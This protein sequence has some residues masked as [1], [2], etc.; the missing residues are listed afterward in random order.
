MDKTETL[1][2]RPCTRTWP[3]LTQA[4]ALFP[5]ASP[6][7]LL[8]TAAGS[9]LTAKRCPPSHCSAQLTRTRGE[10]RGVGGPAQS[11]CQQPQPATHGSFAL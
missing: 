7:C 10:L 3:A 11:A 6:L 1:G 2:L 8:L 4:G 5:V 9:P